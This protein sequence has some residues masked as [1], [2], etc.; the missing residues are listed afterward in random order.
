MKTILVAT[1]KP[2]A[3]IAKASIDRVASAAGYNVKYLEKYPD[4]QALCSAVGNADA[5]IVRSDKVTADVVQAAQRLKIVV[6]AGAGFDNLDLEALKKRGIVAMNT[7]G[8]NANGVAE[9]A[10]AQL[11]FL[12]R[13]SFNPGT[14]VE[15]AGKT[16]GL[17]GFGAVAR[18]VGRKAMQLGMKVRSYDPFVPSEVMKK[19]GVTP[20]KTLSTLYKSCFAVSIHVPALPATIGCVNAAVL[21]AI[22]SDSRHIVLNTARAEIVD[23]DAMFAALAANPNLCYASDVAKP[24]QWERY[25]DSYGS[26]VWADPQKIGA[27]TEESNVRAAQAAAKQ[28]VAF[29]EK[30]DTKYQLN[31]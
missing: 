17:H 19:E 24:Q 12:S 23:D 8:Q 18:L 26:R 10:I 14:G 22:P 31:K 13:N 3:A 30:G 7:P 29:F 4:E 1:Q 16:L 2:F 11:I 25:A 5:L 21:G 20:V 9:L 27:Q 6:R 15:I 28:I